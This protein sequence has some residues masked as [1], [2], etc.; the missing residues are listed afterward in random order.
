MSET[1][2][3]NEINNIFSQKRLVWRGGEA[4]KD[5]ET[6]E[7]AE[8]T[9]LKVRAQD[10]NDYTKEFIQKSNSND[11]KKAM[12]FLRENFIDPV[13]A[14]KSVGEIYGLYPMD[15]EG[16]RALEG[17]VIKA[18]IAPLFTSMGRTERIANIMSSWLGGWIM[19]ENENEAKERAD[20]V[21][22]GET[23]AKEHEARVEKMN[24][25]RKQQEVEAPKDAAEYFFNTQPLSELLGMLATPEQEEKYDEQWREGA[26][27][28]ERRYGADGK[29][30][31]VSITELRDPKKWPESQWRDNQLLN[32]IRLNNYKIEK[33]NGAIKSG[34]GSDKTLEEEMALKTEAMKT[35]ATKV[36]E[37]LKSEIERWNALLEGKSE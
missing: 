20:A 15:D 12:D 7:S 35:E 3:K 17:R 22:K 13:N 21:K 30:S 8:L 4:P 14:A 1:K 33:L 23:Y 10:A 32:E 5:A 18:G 9:E 31:V 37:R 11:I 36:I 34:A 28:E 24:E 6:Q 2:L 25:K 29:G 27:L 19:E 16:V 26:G